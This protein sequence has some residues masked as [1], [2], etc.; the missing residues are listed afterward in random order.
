MMMII[1]IMNTVNIIVILIS[2]VSTYQQTFPIVSSSQYQ[3]F[4]STDNNFSML[5]RNLSIGVT[6]LKQL[7]L[8]NIDLGNLS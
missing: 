3:G 6:L 1:D 5:Y 4:L 2:V 7:M 8:L